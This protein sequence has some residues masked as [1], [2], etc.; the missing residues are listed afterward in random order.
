MDLL[1][2]LKI[3]RSLLYNLGHDLSD[4]KKLGLL[5]DISVPMKLRISILKDNEEYW[6]ESWTVD[7]N[8]EKGMTVYQRAEKRCNAERLDGFC[9]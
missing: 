2:L 1:F 7:Q 6:K 8:S 9:Y 5:S 3:N 4:W